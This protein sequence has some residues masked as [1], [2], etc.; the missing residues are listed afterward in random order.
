MSYKVGRSHRQVKHAYSKY[1]R[2]AVSHNRRRIAVTDASTHSKS[3]FYI[4]YGH[5]SQSVITR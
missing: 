3:Q 1:Y 5:V 2:K 4:E